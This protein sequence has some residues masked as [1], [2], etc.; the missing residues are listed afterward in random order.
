VFASCEGRGRHFA[1]PGLSCDHLQD[2]LTAA[3][4]MLDNIPHNDTQEKQRDQTDPD[5]GLKVFVHG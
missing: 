5:D 2:R 4:L 3:P 1:A